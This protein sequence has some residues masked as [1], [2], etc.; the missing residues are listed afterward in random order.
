MPSEQ[1][2]EEGPRSFGVIVARTA[3]T[4]ERPMDAL[5]L[6]KA[7]RSEGRDVGV[8]L[9]ADGIYIGKKGRTEVAELLGQMIA[10]GVKVHVSPEHIKAAGF[11]KDNPA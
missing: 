1:S 3:S 10:D 2:G 6:A 5:K 9:V 4:T 8:F 7:I 11:S